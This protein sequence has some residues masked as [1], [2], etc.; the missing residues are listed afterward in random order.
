MS[1]QYGTLM[2]RND[3]GCDAPN[4]GMAS[5]HL[6]RVG[7]FEW[8]KL[9]HNG[10]RRLPDVVIFFLNEVRHNGLFFGLTPYQ[11]SRPTFPGPRKSMDFVGPHRTNRKNKT[12]CF[13]GFYYSPG[14]YRILIW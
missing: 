10:N 5:A 11:G 7:W 9:S 8:V 14:Q 3:A 2:F 13:S 1:E 12:R 6:I 4:S